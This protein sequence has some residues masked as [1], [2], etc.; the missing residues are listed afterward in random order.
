MGVSL[1]QNDDADILM[2]TASGPLA[3]LINSSVFYSCT[4]YTFTSKIG[5][6]IRLTTADFDAI[7]N[8]GN[9]YSC[10]SIGSGLPKIEVAGSRVTGHWTRGL[11]NG[12]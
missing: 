6:T 2:K 5:P 12:Q 7:D 11:D 10:G 3:T 9:V 8:V 1:N 4:L